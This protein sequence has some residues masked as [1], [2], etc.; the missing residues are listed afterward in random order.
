[1]VIYG[2]S[3]TT[4]VERRL[5]FDRAGSSVLLT[6]IEHKD[7]TERDRLLVPVE[8]LLSIIMAPPDGERT[9]T[10]QS[11]QY[12]EPCFLDVEIRRNEVWLRARSEKGQGCDIAVGLDD[13]QDALEKV[14]AAD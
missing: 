7:D 8:E 3:Q 10:G 9:V 6:V 14:I 4:G 12:G 13:F 5:R 11:P 1:M 2:V